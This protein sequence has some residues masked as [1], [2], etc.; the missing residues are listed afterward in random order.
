MPKTLSLGAPPETVKR[1]STAVN[2]KLS[3]KDKISSKKRKKMKSK[4]IEEASSFATECS[5]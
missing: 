3:Q 4:S 1:K 5:G 2:R